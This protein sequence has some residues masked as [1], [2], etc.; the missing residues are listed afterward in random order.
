MPKLGPQPLTAFHHLVAQLAPLHITNRGYSTK[1]ILKAILEQGKT[2]TRTRVLSA[3]T[4][5]TRNGNLPQL[6][7][8]Q[9]PRLRFAPP[10][11]VDEK[12][13]MVHGVLKKGH[14]WMG[15]WR[16]VLTYPEAVEAGREGLHQALETFDEK[17]GT[18]FLTHAFNR[19]A[20][21]IGDAVRQ[22][23][24]NWKRLRSLET[25]SREGQQALIDR[26]QAPSD[27]HTLQESLTVLHSLHTKGEVDANELMMFTLSHAF[28]HNGAEIAKH[29][30]YHKSAVSRILS[31]TAQKLKAATEE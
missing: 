16:E 1:Q 8:R 24:I 18:K 10:A 26:I 4:V 3:V 5:L 2:A 6:G 21:R 17:R 13:R 30:N 31:K 9:L 20:S 27:D 22:K 28:G 29:F 25:P 11:E 14:P 15:Q 12:M 7:K 23:V 19:I